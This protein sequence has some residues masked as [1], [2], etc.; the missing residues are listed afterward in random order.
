MRMS[1]AGSFAENVQENLSATMMEE[2]R[3]VVA[4]TVT[5]MVEV[6]TEEATEVG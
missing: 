2:V 4:A 6:G 3:V 5:A 1:P